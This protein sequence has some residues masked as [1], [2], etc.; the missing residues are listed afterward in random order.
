MIH[1]LIIHDNNDSKSGKYFEASQKHLTSKLADNS[2][3]NPLILSTN[4]CEQNSIDFYT[5]KYEGKPFVFIA[6]AHGEK[7]AIYIGSEKYIHSQNAYFF[8]ETLFYACGCLSAQEL[9]VTLAKDFGCK[10][11]IG[12]KEV[13]TSCNPETEP[14]YYTCENEFIKCFL[15]TEST[16]QESLAAMYDKYEEYKCYL[17]A[18]YSTTEASILEKN[19]NAFQLICKDEHFHLTKDYFSH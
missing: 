11:F 4:D 7:D 6:Y 13:I 19:M 16:I 1:L 2:D 9:G 18:Y 12:Y 14:F 15:N 5:S 17:A 3:I 10:V 8:G